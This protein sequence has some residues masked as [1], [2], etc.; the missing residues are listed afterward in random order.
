VYA[1]GNLNS[2]GTA[3]LS[4]LSNVNLYRAG[5]YNAAAGDTHNLLGGCISC[6]GFHFANG[7]QLHGASTTIPKAYPWRPDYARYKRFANVVVN[8]RYQPFGSWDD[9]SNTWV[10]G[11]CSFSAGTQTLYYV[12]GNVKMSGVT[13]FHTAAPRIVARGWISMTTLSIVSSGLLASDVQR[14]ELIAEKDVMIG[15]DVLDMTTPTFQSE[16][17]A[18][19]LGQGVSLATA[20]SHT[21]NLKAISERGSAWAMTS[22]LSA[23]S[24]P[25]MCLLGSQD[26][27][28]AFTGTVGTSV[29]PLH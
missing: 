25:R 12:E 14:I 1:R 21:L 18:M 26:A 9:A 5:S 19:S 17:A 6:V 10:T 22:N 16:S 20:V 11:G 7:S 28:L 8:K 2:T 15:R 29:L 13:L 4:T 23:A 24:T 27:T 3:L